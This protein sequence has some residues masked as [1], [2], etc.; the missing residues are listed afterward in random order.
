[1]RDI[2]TFTGVQGT[3]TN[4]AS[5]DTGSATDD[6]L[7]A[8]AIIAN[9]P[10]SVLE[11]AGIIVTQ[12]LPADVDKAVFPILRNTQLTWT[13]ITPRTQSNDFGSEFNSSE[14]N[15]VGFTT[16]TPLVR[17]ANIFLS[18]SL[19]LVNKIT[20]DA[21]AKQAAVDAKRYMEEFGMD[22]LGSEA[23][24]TNIYAAGGKF[25]SAGSLIAGSTL[26]PLDL[27]Y[28]K[29]LL[30]TGSDP[31]VPDFVL[32][33]PNEYD[34]L[35]THAD[36]APGASTNGA[37]L[38]KARFNEDGDIVRFDGMDLYVTELLPLIG[39]TS[40]TSIEQTN[41]AWVVSGHPVIV[42]KKGQCL[43]RAQHSG[44]K[45]STEDSRLKHGQYKII[46]VSFGYGILRKEAMVYLRAADS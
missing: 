7:F 43:A 12:T 42:G 40:L 39:S 36:F 24:H 20:F 28:S 10:T 27:V 18:D 8:E 44:I 22:T 14:L 45:V 6:M 15:P 23:N 41:D 21:L 13:A 37:M 4:L 5:I 9:E 19:S 17:S 38:R 34:N 26:C 16:V 11:E 1:M 30:S 35:N 31:S 32:M 2:E 3:P 25:A 29:R 33:H 46:D